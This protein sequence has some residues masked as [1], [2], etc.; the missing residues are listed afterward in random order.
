MQLD[1]YRL[2]GRSGLRVSPL[3]LGAMTFGDEDGRSAG[4]E[5]SRQIM[6]AYGDRGGNFIDTAN[7]YSYGRSEELI[8]EFIADRRSRY[9][10]ATKYSMTMEEGQPNSGG[11]HR[12]NM[13]ESVEAS[14][15]RLRTDYIDLLGLH[16]WDFRSPLDEVMRALDDLVRSGKV[17]YGAVSDTPAWKVAAANTMAELRG[18]TPFIAY[19]AQYNLIE[20]TSD[21]EIRPMCAEH[22]LTLM[23]WS[24]LANG[25]LSGKY[26]RV[27]MGPPDP[28]EIKTGSRRGQLQAMGAFNEHNMNVLDVLKG[29]AENVDASV[30]QVALAWL[31]ARPGR[32]LPI[33]GARTLTQLE[34]NLGCLTVEL[35]AEHV[36]RLDEVSAI[37]SGFPNQLYE[38]V[39]LRNRLVDRNTA[40]E[41][42]FAVKYD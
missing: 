32:P 7:I 25:L 2:L 42:G 21:R 14:L 15:K 39:M 37:D 22:G 28:G 4:P 24:P 33:I 36:A 29:V 3:C 10:I 8:G 16:I 20:R 13:I 18:W 34:D 41:G 1:E 5:V 6:E 12:K 35:S 17:F 19:Q 9:V 40:V 27:D 30:S 38:S 11:N 31:L 23:P 26:S